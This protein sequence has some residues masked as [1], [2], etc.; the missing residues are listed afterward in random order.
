MNEYC[1]WNSNNNGITEYNHKKVFNF[2]N[3][4]STQISNIIYFVEIFEEINTDM[5]LVLRL[6]NTN[7]IIFLLI[8]ND[9]LNS[10]YLF[11][12]IFSK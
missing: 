8:K 1:F 7:N 9:Y 4:I 2:N 11:L 5:A 12:F 3:N 10:I 6:R